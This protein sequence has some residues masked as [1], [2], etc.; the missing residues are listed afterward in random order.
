MDRTRAITE[1]GV[2]VPRG[3]AAATQPFFL[4]LHYVNPHAPYTPPAPFDTAFLDD[5]IDG[6][7]RAARRRRLPRRHPQGN[8][9]CRGRTGSATTSRSTTARSRPWTRRWGASW[10]R[11]TPPP[12][13]AQTLVVLTSDH[14]ESL[15]EHDYYFDHGEDLFDPCLRIPLIVAGAGRRG[16]PRGA[17]LRCH[18]ARPRADG[19]GR[20][21]GLVPARP[22]GHEPAG[23]RCAGQDRPGRERLFAQND[24]NLTATWDRALQAR[25]HAGR[26]DDCATRSFDR[27]E[28]PGRDA[29]RG[30]G[31][32]RT[33]CASSR[34]ELELFLER[35]DQEWAQTRRLLEGQAAGGDAR[36]P[37]ACEQL[38][39]L[40]Y[41]A[42]G[43]P[44]S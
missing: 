31:R 32:S 1:D 20:G 13:R 36:A 39:A 24:R 38:R 34:R 33:R 6:R 26:R 7:G 25:G 41:V 28:G 18:H 5:G 35:A 43:L 29:E 44:A 14:G 37:T 17:H 30:R 42:V 23:P 10:T 16:R 11:S 27:S 3:R 8:G 22:R 15:G 12:R 19:A 21:Q 2:R 9:P 40:G 4:W